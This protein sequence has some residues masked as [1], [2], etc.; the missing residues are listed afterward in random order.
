VICKWVRFGYK[1]LPWPGWRAFLLESHLDRCS[2]CQERTL[3]DETIRT[4]GITAA[5]LQAE[6]PLWPVPATRHQSRAM[7]FGWRY[8]FGLSLAAALVW[9]AIAVGR[10]APSPV[11]AVLNGSIQEVE[12]SDESSVFAVLSA[13]IGTE[14]ARPVIFKPRQ[15]GLTIVWFEK[16]KN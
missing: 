13:K 1:L 4:M 6:F 16:I 11:S 10:F 15:P 3:D 5:D 12:N 9:M 7:H 14:S 8:V 2:F